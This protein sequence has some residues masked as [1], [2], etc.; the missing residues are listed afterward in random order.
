MRYPE[1]IIRS[2][3]FFNQNDFTLT[4]GIYIKQFRGDREELV[5]INDGTADLTFSAGGIQNFK[6]SPGETFD[7]AMHPFS[8]LEVTANGAFRGYCREVADSP[9]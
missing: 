1:P 8:R 2:T 5:V 7:E 3:D 9:N 6:L 4:N